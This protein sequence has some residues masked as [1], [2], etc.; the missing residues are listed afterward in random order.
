MTRQW[1][2]S[3]TGSLNEGRVLHTATLL[4]DGRVLV[5][6]GIGV[7]G[8]LVSVELYDPATG[9][10]S[11]TGSLGTRRDGHTATLLPDGRVLVVGG[12]GDDGYLASVEVYDPALGI[13]SPVDE[14]STARWY[15]T[16]TLLPDGRVLVAGG[17]G[18]EGA[19]AD[20]WLYD[21][22]AAPGSAWSPTGT[23]IT[24]RGMHTA[25]LLPDGRILVVGGLGGHGPEGYLPGAEVYDPVLG[26]WSLTGS[27]SVP[28][29]V[30][31]ATL[32]VAGR[33]LVAGGMAGVT[34][35]WT[36]PKCTIRL[37]ARGAPQD[38]WWMPARGTRRS[39]C[40]MARY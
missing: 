39:C 16:A 12:Y 9:T 3:P 27:M 23:M 22:T 33:V 37:Q 28:R 8:D 15:H 40:P 30:H 25:T 32:L 36:A 20:A 21:P 14:L 24:S 17:F 18:I 1:G 5:A 26:T 7:S 6:G 38:R 2:L 29:A 10:W 31:S 13:W 34:R 35:S 11:L 4:A 19:L